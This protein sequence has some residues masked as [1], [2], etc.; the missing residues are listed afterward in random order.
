[1]R[2]LQKKKKH[3]DIE[4]NIHEFNTDEEKSQSLQIVREC[5]LRPNVKSNNPEEVKVK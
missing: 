1:M 4:Q 2:S 5:K 3:S